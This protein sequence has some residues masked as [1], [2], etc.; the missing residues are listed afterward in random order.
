MGCLFFMAKQTPQRW[1][2]R[3]VQEANDICEQRTQERLE[4]RLRKTTSDGRRLSCQRR[5][6][7]GSDR[8]RSGGQFA[9]RDGRQEEPKQFEEAGQRAARD[10]MEGEACEMGESG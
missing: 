2:K 10:V 8:P 7:S 9:K 5:L 6:N 4:R 1:S 3:L